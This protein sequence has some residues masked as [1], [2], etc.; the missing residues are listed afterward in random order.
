MN[1]SPLFDTRKRSCNLIV[2]QFTKLKNDQCTQNTDEKQSSGPG[3]Y[4]TMDAN[5]RKCG[6]PNKNCALENIGMNYS[7]GFGWGS[8]NGCLIENDSELRNKSQL[9]NQRTK[10]QLFPRS[11]LEGYRGNGDRDIDAENF[12]MVGKEDPNERK[13]C[14]VTS[15]ISLYPERFDELFEHSNP[16]RVQHIVP[17]APTQGGWTWGGM[18]TRMESRKKSM[19]CPF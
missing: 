9:T 4:L 5:N 10:Y 2:N 19:K 8:V 18:D 11:I 13:P 6:I 3:Q 12:I 17:P 15:G 1:N 7:D 14:E 16:Q